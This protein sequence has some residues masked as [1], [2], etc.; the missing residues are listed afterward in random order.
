MGYSLWGSKES[1]VTERLSTAHMLYNSSS[2]LFYFIDLQNTLEYTN[3]SHMHEIDIKGYSKYI[4]KD[5]A[6]WDS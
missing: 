6:S 5:T 2:V 3:H 1:D 4:L